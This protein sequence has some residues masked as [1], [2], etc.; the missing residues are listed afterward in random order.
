MAYGVKI[1]RAAQGAL[2]DLPKKERQRIAQKIDALQNEARPQGSKKL[3]GEEKLHRIRIGRYRVVYEIDDAKKT[4]E[5]QVVGHRREIY[6]KGARH[7]R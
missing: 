2:R 1:L 5:I 4:V 6:R 7:H 3:K